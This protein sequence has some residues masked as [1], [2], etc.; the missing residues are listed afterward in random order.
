MRKKY[1]SIGMIDEIINDVE[2]YAR[3]VARF[4][5]QAVS[6]AMTKTAHDAIE[7]FYSS[8]TP[9][10]YFRTGNLRQSYKKVYPDYRAVN[11]YT[12]GVIL[13]SDFM[14]DVYTHYTKN[15]SYDT[16]ELVFNLAYAGFHGLKAWDPVY[17]EDGKFLYGVPIEERPLVPYYVTTPSPTEIIEKKYNSIQRNNSKYIKDAEAKAEKLRKIK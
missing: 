14:D 5:A 10:C 7:K 12:G 13:S 1:K 11:K 4:S 15:G 17:G 9:N 8:Y 6:D 2:A 3:N 16:R